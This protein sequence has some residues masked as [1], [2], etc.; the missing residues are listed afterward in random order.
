MYSKT[1][2]ISL[3]NIREIRMSINDTLT[4]IPIQPRFKKIEACNIAKEHGAIEITPDKVTYM[5][6]QG[7]V[8]PH[9]TPGERRDTHLYGRDQISTL[10]LINK[11]KEEKGFSYT[12]IVSLLRDELDF[13]NGG[14]KEV[15]SKK[16]E[17]GLPPQG[18]R[19]Q[20]ILNSRI[21]AI[22][23]NQLLGNY[24]KPGLILHLRERRITANIHIPKGTAKL[25]HSFMDLK[26]ADDFVGNFRDDD[27]LAFISPEPDRE[28]LFPPFTQKSLSEF[29]IYN[30]MLITVKLGYPNQHFDLMIG[31]PESDLISHVRIPSENLEVSI[32]GLLM[33]IAFLKPDTSKVSDEIS[34]TNEFDRSTMLNALV[35]FIPQVSETWEYC[36]VFTGSVETPNHLRISA[37]SRDFPKDLRQEVNNIL[38]EPGQP[39]TGWAFNTTYPIVIQHTSGPY[40]P[41]LAYQ[42]IEKATAAI[43]LPTRARDQYNG[44]LYIGTRFEVPADIP[45]FSEAEIRGL[46]LIS[47][48]I[49]EVI[50]RNRIRK[51]SE[52][53]SEGTISLPPLKFQGWERLGDEI[54]ST[55]NYV[56]RQTVE[57]SENDNL[58][59]TLV[60]VEAH[61]EIYRKNPVISEWLT[62][63]ILETTRFFYI[64]N[65]L[66]DPKIFLHHNAS[67]FSQISEFVCFLPEIN[68]SDEEDRRLRNELRELL[69][70]LKLS[71]S[72]EDHFPVLTNVWSMPFRYTGLKRRVSQCDSLEVGI[73]EVTKE[74]LT[75]VEDALVIIPNIEK[76]HHH[77]EEQAYSAALSEYLAAY[78]FAPN[79]RYI[80]R[81]IAKTY[82]AIGD[83]KNSAIWWKIILKN[84][85]HPS[86][87]SRYAY[88]LARM[89]DISGAIQN[90]KIAFDLDPTNFKVLLEWGDL[91]SIEGKPNEA[92]QKYESA[93]RIEKSERDLLWLRM[94]EVYIE[95]TDFEKARTFAKLVLDRRPDNQEARRLILKVEK[96][97]K[98]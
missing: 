21:L 46:F 14:Q 59:L 20:A 31:A 9:V 16:T 3:E 52:K 22:L 89:G 47:D 81:H 24:L 92:I 42:Y 77:E 48:I 86:H 36:A 76:G 90:Y 33:K 75:E 83:L 74:L 49:G 72:Y 64:R 17:V 18:K 40:D 35:N 70:S 23:L 96:H 56:I 69:S 88:V 32:I 54:G 65:K 91:L 67:Q 38:I 25:S 55:L 13:R 12:Q 97:L 29:H 68:I 6:N 1:G 39:L 43:A 5:V 98:E 10:I 95:L 44:V 2:K 60:G 84:E 79:N 66:G 28:I 61:S 58:H 94:A 30:W 41:R 63:H 11:L 62:N 82:S 8:I 34:T 51:F 73:A 27:L 19:G 93:L 71:F 37:V 4:G 15:L 85:P 57:P 53:A 45:A 80:Q 50:E 26:A 78:Y 87:Y 7:L